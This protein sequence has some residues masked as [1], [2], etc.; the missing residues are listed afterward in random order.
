MSNDFVP[1]QVQ[2]NVNRTR[3]ITGQINSWGKWDKALLNSAHFLCPIHHDWI[4]PSMLLWLWYLWCILTP[5][6]SIQHHNSRRLS[7]QTEDPS[8]ADNTD[9]ARACFYRRWLSNIDR[10]KGPFAV[11]MKLSIRDIQRTCLLMVQ[12]QWIKSTMINTVQHFILVTLLSNGPQ[13]SD[14]LLSEER[15]ELKLHQVPLSDKP[16]KLPGSKG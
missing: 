14:S 2:I 16:P 1:Y 7:S 12:W 13:S 4:Q 3:K 9:L 15:E 10:A 5:L 6:R 8:D 11:G